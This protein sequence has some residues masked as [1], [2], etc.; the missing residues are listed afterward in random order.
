MCSLMYSSEMK[1]TNY[2][3]AIEHCVNVVVVVPKRRSYLCALA[4]CVSQH[5]ELCLQTFGSGLLFT[6][7]C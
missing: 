2:S 4:N 6:E 3:K 1:L 5:A 7:H